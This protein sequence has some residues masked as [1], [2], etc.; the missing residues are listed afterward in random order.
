VLEG[1][2]DAHERGD[3]EAS[4]E[5]IADDIRVTM[6]PHP[7]LFEGREEI[8]QLMEQANGPEAPG[9]WRL[10]PTSANR[11]PAAASYL[12]RPGDSTYRAFKLDVLRVVDR[13]IA[14]E[15]R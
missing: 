12:L 8:A 7:Y 2:I 9:V 6:P 1:F 14:T 13:K 15:R 11:Q 4:L 10:V 5:L 3:T